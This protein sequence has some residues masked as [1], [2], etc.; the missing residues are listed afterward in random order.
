MKTLN[1]FFAFAVICVF[2]AQ[3][4]QAFTSVALG[5]AGNHKVVCF[6]LPRETN[7]K[8]YRVEASSDSINYEVVGT[9]R[10]TGNSV[11]AKSYRYE[12]YEPAY[13]YYRIGMVGMNATLQYSA[14]I[15]TQDQQLRAVPTKAQSVIAG[16]A[17]VSGNGQK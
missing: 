1:F 5:N 3:G 4:Q 12:L 2:P 15:K 7:I 11:L 6:S 16:P 14:V 17:I 10:S 13:K 8:Y 9:I